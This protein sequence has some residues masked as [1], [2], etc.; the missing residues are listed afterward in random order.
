MVANPPT[1]VKF[2]TLI[3]F[4]TNQNTG[5]VTS[6]FMSAPEGLSHLVTKYA[7]GIDAG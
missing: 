6:D 4:N 5:S 7:D 2:P 1:T 3:G